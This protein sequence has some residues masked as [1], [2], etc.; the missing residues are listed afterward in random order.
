MPA[1]LALNGNVLAACLGIFALGPLPKDKFARGHY[2][3][4]YWNKRAAVSRLSARVEAL[5]ARIAAEGAGQNK[6]AGKAKLPIP[7]KP[8]SPGELLKSSDS[9]LQLVQNELVAVRSKPVLW[10]LLNVNSLEPG[11][12]G[13]YPSPVKVVQVPSPGVIL[14]RSADR[15]WLI[16]G[17]NTGNVADGDGVALPGPVE[18]QGTKS[19]TA[20]DG[21]KRT[22]RALKL[23]DLRP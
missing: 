2:V 3:D 6:Q 7:S 13:T 14:A 15:L 16:E 12:V 4:A 5:E 10:K 22:V 23:L 8:K 20:A 19:Y 11:K 18:Y 17:L 1:L 21:T 9:Q